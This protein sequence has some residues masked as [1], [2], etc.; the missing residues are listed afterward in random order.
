MQLPHDAAAPLGA[1]DPNM[2]SSEQEKNPIYNGCPIS[3]RGPPIAIY[4]EAFARLKD[5]LDHPDTIQVTAAE[6]RMTHALFLASTEFY[7][8]DE[9]WIMKTRGFW[10]SLLGLRIRRI[11]LDEGTTF[12]AA[13]NPK[14]G[15]SALLCSIEWKG[16]FGSTG[17]AGYKASS[18]FCKFAAQSM[19]YF[20]DYPFSCLS[21]TIVF[22]NPLKYLQSVL[23][24]RCHG[25]VFLY[26][27]RRFC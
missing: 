23:A 3:R 18:A 6:L 15:V 1:T 12:G 10:E 8:N 25:T 17:D 19:V 4:H 16:E 21:L 27:G 9:D 7:E 11:I 13:V 5:D 14:V 22:K 2:M 26:H 24:H 20:S